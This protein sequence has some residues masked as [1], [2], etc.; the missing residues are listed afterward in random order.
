MASKIILKKSSVAS[1]APV[2]GDLDFGELAINYTDS[3]L[4]FKKAD[5]S[6][7][8]FT[9]AAASAP[10][11][12]VGG[13]IG[14]ITDT[15]LLTSIK[16]V[17]GSGSGLDADFLDGNHASAFYLASNP[18]G[19]TSNTGTV[20]SVGA[21]S[22]LVSSGGNTPSL[23]IPAAN[24]TTDGYMS[25]AYASKL[26]GI[27]A[28]ATAN[29]GTVTSVAASAGTGI[30]VTGSPITSTGT[31]TITNTAPNVTTDISITH[32]ASTVVV[33]SS[34]GTDGTINAATTT[35]AG[36]MTAADKSKLDGIAAGATNVTN[37]NQ[38]T[39]GAGYITSSASIT[40]NAATATALQTAR[41][42]NG[43]SFN[44]S[45]NIDTTEWFHSDRDFPNGTLI[46]T[47]INYAVSSGDPFVLEIRGNSYGNIVPL[48]LL[49]QGYIYADTII[50]HGGI[51][52]GLNITGLV[53]I[54]NGG[55]L[56]FWFPSQG[57]WNGYNVKVY[58]AYATRAVNRVTSISGV[59]K[60]TTAKEVALSDNI[61]QSLHSSNYTSYSPS[62]TGGGASGT[63]GINITGN[64]ATASNGGVTSVNGQTGAV[65]VT[66]GAS[67]SAAN[68]WTAAN[69]F[70]GNG[71]TASSSGIGMQ[72]YSTSSNGAI[73][74]FHRAGVY[75]VNMGLDSDNVL[76]IG[77]WSAAAN[78]FQMDM[79][80]NLTMAGNV[81]A[82]SDENL[83]KD[84][85]QLPSSFVEELSNV[86]SG[87]YTRIDSEER[88]AGCSA[89]DWQKILPE[90]VSQSNDGI[91]SLAYGNAA[92]VSSV[93]LAKRIVEQDK[94]IAELERLVSKLIGD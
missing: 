54:N 4:Y 73:M 56:C 7:D 70:T 14:D 5:G 63:W 44:G 22:P 78:R 41:T 74:A 30:S 11:T 36:A 35:L 60:P 59:A 47:N 10:V 16:N 37:T 33:N 39:N 46:T 91:L 15:Q 71:N 31:L 55:N 90:V 75:A 9:S 18:N 79:S 49:Y 19:Y 81:T 89:Q 8:A 6:I 84:W 88:Q 80:G 64:A 3:K 61:R 92:L 23:S 85:E 21:T 57:Y 26:D 20:T 1:K 66:T 13:N 69:Q 12:S 28:G 67:L 17:D 38:L 87:T 93:E 68:T 52:N 72:A 50:N 40:G 42:I 25:S 24:S 83:K 29:T 34:D 82:F 58:T 27:A 45:V 51:S 94:R 2:A 77:G 53:A 48:D 86:R 76:R 62:L 43:I 65:T 32:N